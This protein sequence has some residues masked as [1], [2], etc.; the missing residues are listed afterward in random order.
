MSDRATIEQSKAYHA[1]QKE[2]TRLQTKTHSGVQALV[3]DFPELADLMYAISDL[4]EA[5]K[6]GSGASWDNE[7][8][9]NS[10]PI[11]HDGQSTSAGRQ[12][13]PA[14][15]TLDR[16]RRKIAQQTEAIN[17]DLDP[18]ATRPADTR[19]RHQAN[20]C[21]GK[22]KRQPHGIQVCGFCGK[23]IKQKPKAKTVNVQVNVI[24]DTRI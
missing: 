23:P 10:D 16:W 9:G 19:P 17:N 22:G 4:V 21:P 18:M 7:V 20:D 13:L 12:T 14:R 5:A 11:S 6:V 24:N 15:R 3:F 8:K 2:R 1:W